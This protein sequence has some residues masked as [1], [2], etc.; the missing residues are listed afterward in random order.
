MVVVVVV[1]TV[2]VVIAFSHWRSSIRARDSLLSRL[3]RTHYTR[4]RT[5]RGRTCRERTA[6]TRSYD[7]FLSL[8][9]SLS[10]PRF[11]SPLQLGVSFAASPSLFFFLSFSLIHIHPYQF[12]LPSSGRRQTLATLPSTLSPARSQRRT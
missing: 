3:Y 5:H 2:V 12:S 6:W 9:V 8:S 4:R 7:L 11:P 10:F 1:V